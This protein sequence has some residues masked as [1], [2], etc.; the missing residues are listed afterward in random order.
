[1]EEH[2]YVNEFTIKLHGTRS[3]LKALAVCAL[4]GGIY[5]ATVGSAIGAVQGAAGIIAIA[6]GIFAVPCG[7]TG[8]RIGTFIGVVTR[9]RFGQLFLALFAA[10]GGALLGGFLATVLL[11]A[12]G[13][14]LGS[15]GGWVLAT[16]IIALRHDV[17][18][19]F[20]LGIAGATLGTFV[21]AILWAIHLQQIAA[22]A[23]A[24]W[25]AGVGAIVAP[26]LLL[27]VIAALNSFTK[28]RKDHR[29]T[30]IDTR[31]EPEEREDRPTSLPKR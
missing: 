20:F 16:G 21:G 14:V 11:L 22:L 23:G 1:M 7:L 13:A 15:V 29:A 12:F 18:R 5:T 30:Y 26:L 25:G 4:L 9:N 8:A 3:L 19:R 2:D 24:A 27:A 31:F 6:A 17:V 10:I 28:A